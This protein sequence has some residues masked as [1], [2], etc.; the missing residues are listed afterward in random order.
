ML[1]IIEKF[2]L[3]AFSEE[4]LLDICFLTITILSYTLVKRP[5]LMSA[6]DL[7]VVNHLPKLLDPVSPLLQSRVC[8]FLSFY[9][10]QLLTT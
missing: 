8:L 2:D 4:E 10:D 9:I 7:F 5:D 1:E 3:K 6:L